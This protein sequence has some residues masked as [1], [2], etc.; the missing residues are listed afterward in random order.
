VE[1]GLNESRRSEISEVKKKKEVKRE[2][3]SVKFVN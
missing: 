2:S 1:E 3:E